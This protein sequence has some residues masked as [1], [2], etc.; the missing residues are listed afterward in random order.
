MIVDTHTHLLDTGHW[1]NE[2]W[3]W[4]AEDWARQAPGRKPS[5]VRSR[6]ERGL[7]DPDGSRMVSRMDQAGVD[8]SVVLPIDWGP[9]FTGTLPITAVVD[10]ALELAA[11]HPDRLIPFAGIDPRRDGAL[12]LVRSWL[13]RGARGLKLYPSCGWDL[14][15]T[16]AMEIYALCEERAAPVLFHTGHPLPVLDAERSN[17]LLLREVATTF[18]ALPLWLGHAGAPVW[19]EEALEV[20]HA[21]PNVRLEMSVW[22]WDDSDADAEIA[23]TRKVLRVGE[24]LGFQRLLFGT[25]HVSGA[26]VRPSGFLGSVLDMYRRL[27]EHAERLGGSIDG[28]QLAALLGGN[29]AAD[30]GLTKPS[31][32]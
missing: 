20:A 7:I 14:S 9:D 24:E 29:A 27:P 17:P 30:L 13:D 5:D 28:A 26:K 21:G 22:L 4:V 32:E 31:T 16:A 6:I 12:D 15:S 2:W 1:P 10:Q 3:D 18:P 19:W 11:V 25:D 8:A 23:F